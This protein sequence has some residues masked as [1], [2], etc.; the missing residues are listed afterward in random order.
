M[1]RTSTASEK[2]GMRRVR[3]R[4]IEE[5][6]RLRFDQL[7]QKGHSLHSARLGRRCFRHVAGLDDQRVAL[8]SSSGADPHLKARGQKMGWTPRQRVRRLLPVVNDSRFLVPAMRAANRVH[9][10]ATL[11]NV[12]PGL[13]EL[14]KHRDRDVGTE[15]SGL[16]APPDDGSDDPVEHPTAI[17]RQGALEAGSSGRTGADAPLGDGSYQTRKPPLAGLAAPGHAGCRHA[18]V[19]QRF[20][21]GAHGALEPL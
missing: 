5:S 9:V 4:L 13:C 14:Q 20:V 16:G 21:I 18:G 2:P 6:E 12:V 3:V 19:H 15:F 10:M 17:A 1:N 11:R 7:P 8:L